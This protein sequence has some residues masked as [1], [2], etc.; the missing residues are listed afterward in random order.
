MNIRQSKKSP[1]YNE[2][3]DYTRNGACSRCGACCSNILPLTEADIETIRKYIYEHDTEPCLHAGDNSDIAIDF[4]CPFLGTGEDGAATC[5][6]YDVRPFVCRLFLCS[7]ADLS[8][9]T[10]VQYTL[11]GALAVQRGYRSLEDWSNKT[12]SSNMGQTFF[13]DDYAPAKD[14]IVVINHR[15]GTIYAA[16][17]DIPFIA[18]QVNNEKIMIHAAKTDAHE[19]I[20][21]STDIQNVTKAF[22]LKG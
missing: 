9:L 15:G 13:P 5:E 2:V 14:D 21:L 3:T 7:R 19:E 20:R 1:D 8:Q 22:K 10:D 16:Y 12:V 11:L 17:K 6:I 4:I 18:E